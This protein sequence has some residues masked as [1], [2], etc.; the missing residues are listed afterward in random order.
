LGRQCRSKLEKQYD[1]RVKARF[2]SKY[3]KATD[4][5][6]QKF[7]DEFTLNFNAE[8]RESRHPLL[9]RFGKQ[10]RDHFSILSN[11]SSEEGQWVDAF[12]DE[13]P[14]HLLSKLQSD[15][16]YLVEPEPHAYPIAKTDDSDP[17]VSFVF[18]T[19]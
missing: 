7:F 19:A 10:A 2:V 5:D 14:I 16:L 6:I 4:A 17:C 3:P 11:L 9:T 13:E 15:I 1:L 18:T 12:V 8:I